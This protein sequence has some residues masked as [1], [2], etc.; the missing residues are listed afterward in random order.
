[1][2]YGTGLEK[3]IT[4]IKIEESTGKETRS[5]VVPTA[6]FDTGLQMLPWRLRVISLNGGVCKMSA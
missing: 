2:C 5:L 4:M 6:A 1:M 3:N